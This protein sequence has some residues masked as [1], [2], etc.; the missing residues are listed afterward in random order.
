MANT[1]YNLAAR[2]TVHLDQRR[3]IQYR[4]VDEP[5]F[6]EK[7]LPEPARKVVENRHS[8]P[9]VKKLPG[10]MAADIPDPADYYYIHGFIIKE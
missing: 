10:Y 4:N 9:L 2:K 5:R 8:V 7:V 6:G 1:L 3:I